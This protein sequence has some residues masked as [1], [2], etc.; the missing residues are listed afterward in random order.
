MKLTTKTRCGTRLLLELARH[1]GQSPVSVGDAAKTLD[2]SVKYLEQIIRSL[3]KAH[4]VV[5]TRGPKGGHAL[6]KSPEEISLGYIVRR[7]QGSDAL[8]NCVYT[9]E[10]CIRSD[11]CRV[12]IAWKQA[13]EALYAKL[14]SVTIN[15]L[16]V[17]EDP[18]CEQS[19]QCYSAK[20]KDG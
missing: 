9:P 19:A 10:D 17:S 8:T 16:L 12:R 18:D 11:E 14:D 5:S 4:L 2:V 7:L 20:T 13:T 3:K 6:A 1:Y 15:D